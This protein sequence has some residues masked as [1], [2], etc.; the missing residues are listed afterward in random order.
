M[1]ILGID[2]GLSGA[3]ALFD[4]GAL[5]VF[6]VPTVKARARGREV[7]WSEAARWI[8]AAGHIDHAIIES[9][10]AMPRQGVASMFKFG[11]VCGGLRALVA[12]HF[13]P[14]TYVSP[15]KWK[16]SLSVPKAKDGARARASELFPLYSHLWQR[17]KDDGRAEAAMI[18]LYGARLLSS[19]ERMGAAA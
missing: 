14:V 5:D 13:I 7:D 8:D 12:A 2:P 15:K 10:A 6:D 9:A 16:G 1:R 17:V 18:A 11:F 3:L 19:G 4:D